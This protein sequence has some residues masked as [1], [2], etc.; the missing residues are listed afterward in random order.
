MDGWH[1]LLHNATAKYGQTVSLGIVAKYL[2]NEDT[3]YSVLESLKHAAWAK[4]VGLEYEWV[5]AEQI[6]QEGTG[7]LAKYDGLLVPGGFGSR[8]IEGKIAAATYALEHNKPYLGLC[9]GLQMA[10]IAA[11]RRGGLEGATS[12]EVDPA[13]EQNVVYIMAEQKGKEATGGTM[14]LGN[15]ECVFAADSLA[16]KLYG[17]DR[18]MERHRHRYE[19]NRHFEKEINAGGVIVS[20]ASP[21]GRLVEVVEAENHPFFIATQAHPEF[22]SRPNRPHPLFDGFI[23]AAT[24]RR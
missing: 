19:V 15:Y 3:Y 18:T 9:L 23:A 10:V 6:E 21:D 16:K 1:E 8:G 7:M 24:K 12:E 2:D 5:N 17:K 22:L 4:R 11:A 20:G 13:A 14:R